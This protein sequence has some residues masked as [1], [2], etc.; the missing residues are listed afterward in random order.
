MQVFEASFSLFV[1]IISPLIG[2]LL[3]LGLL[4]GV[5]KVATQID[6]KSLGFVLKFSLVFVVCY[7]FAGIWGNQ[8]ANFAKEIWGS[9]QYYNQS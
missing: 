3:L 6:D 9:M 2:L 5:L 1:G 7:F 4:S 8:V